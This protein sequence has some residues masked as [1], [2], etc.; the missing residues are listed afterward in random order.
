MGSA[1]IRLDAHALA[2][3]DGGLASGSRDA[4]PEAPAG[5]RASARAL[6][7]AATGFAG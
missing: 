6:V 4:A 1:G 5:A 2:C 7:T 3:R